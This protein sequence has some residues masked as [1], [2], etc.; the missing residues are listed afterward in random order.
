MS[1][2]G[3]EETEAEGYIGPASDWCGGDAATYR[4]K[5]AV[6][7]VEVSAGV[8]LPRRVRVA[9]LDRTE[10]DR[11]SAVNV[12][13]DVRDWAAMRSRTSGGSPRVGINV[14]G[15]GLLHLDALRVVARR[16]G[17]A[18]D[19]VGVGLSAWVLAMGSELTH[20]DHGN[21]LWRE[22]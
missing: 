1:R 8:A 4:A 7:D 11:V 15:G 20:R 13:Y 10:D 12:G 6:S 5:H 22:R 17:T 2:K 21:A 18:L 3:G 16:R 19:C 14:A 9:A